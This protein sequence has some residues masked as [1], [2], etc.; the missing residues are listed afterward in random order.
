MPVGVVAWRQQQRFRG[1]L[2]AAAQQPADV[3]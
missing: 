1:T 2:S 3:V